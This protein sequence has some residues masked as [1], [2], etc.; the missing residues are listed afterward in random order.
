MGDSEKYPRILELGKRW[1]SVVS[2]TIRP[3]YPN[4]KGIGTHLIR[5]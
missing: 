4:E 1:S 3:L 5:G 2:F